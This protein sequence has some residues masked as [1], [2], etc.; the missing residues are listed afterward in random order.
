MRVEIDGS[1][2]FVDIQGA[3]LG[4]GADGQ[5]YEKPTLVVV[6]GGP[7]FD[8]SVFRPYYDRFA[9]VAQVVYF[10]L[11]GHGRSDLGDPTRWNLAAWGREVKSL[12]DCL[13]IQRPVVAGVSFGGFVTMSYAA[14]FPDHALGLVLASTAA[15]TDMDRKLAAFEAAGGSRARTIAQAFWATPD[16]ANVAAYQEVCMP[17]Y[18]PPGTVVE[19]TSRVIMRLES[20]YH[21]TGAGREMMTYDFRPALGAVQCPVLVVSGGLDPITPPG[22]SAEIIACLPPGLARSQVFPECGHGVER[23]DPEGYERVLRGF[24]AELSGG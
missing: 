11:T 19:P 23:T 7:G 5:Y 3:G 4:I 20:F 13:G 18:T 14:Q 12:C 6:H 2:V 1:K 10:D 16:A 21:F 8:H 17:L 9:D 22:D 15:R 24:L